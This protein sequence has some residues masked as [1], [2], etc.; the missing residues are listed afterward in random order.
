[1]KKIG[2]TEFLHILEELE[3]YNVLD[4]EKDL[5]KDIKLKKVGLK[6]DK[7]ELVHALRNVLEGRFQPS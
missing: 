4:V 3:F 1:M 6:V 7:K 2:Q 5:K